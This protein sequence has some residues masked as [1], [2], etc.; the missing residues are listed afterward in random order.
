MRT[1][2]VFVGSIRRNLTVHDLVGEFGKRISSKRGPAVSS[3]L[4][5]NRQDI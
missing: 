4:L 3:V 2:D 5:S 1:K